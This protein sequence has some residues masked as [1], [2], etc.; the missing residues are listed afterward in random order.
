MATVTH[1]PPGWWYGQ[2]GLSRAAS[3]FLWWGL[4]PK[5][6]DGYNTGVRSY[7]NHCVTHCNGSP[8][9]ATVPKLA[10]WLGH[11]GT[12]RITYETMKKY[13]CGIRSHHVDLSYSSQ[14]NEVFAHPLLQRICKGA[15]RRQGQAGRRE[16]RPITRDVLL[17]MLARLD[18]NTPDGANMHAAF[19]LAFAGFLRVGEFTYTKADT[20]TDD[21]GDWFVTR[22]HVSLGRDSLTLD[23]PASK[24]DTFRRGISIPIAATNDAACPLKSLRHLFTEYP[25][26]GGTPLFQASGGFSRQHVTTTLRRLLLDIGIKG[27]FSAHSF[28]RGAATWAEIRGIPGDQIRALG[29]W[30]SDSYLLYIDRGPDRILAYSKQFQGTQ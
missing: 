26:K 10:D 3:L 29:R 7:L 2:T 27:R 13:M 4:A 17:K 5:T 15:R 9:P 28:R 16:R 23:I 20:Q 25:A 14:E 12:R 1:D 22:N 11:L 19:C 24:T 6:R 18:T 8:F 30:R 21:F